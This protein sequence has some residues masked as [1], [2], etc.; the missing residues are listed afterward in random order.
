MKLFFREHIP[1]FLL[2]LMQLIITILIFWLDGYKNAS[3]ILYASFINFF[4]LTTY[5]VYQFLSHRSLYMRLTK[6]VTTLDHFQVSAQSA[7][8]TQ[9]FEHLLGILR[10]RYKKE[11]YTYKDKLDQHVQFIHQWVHQMKTPLSVID[12]ILQEQNQSQVSPIL[13]EL[14]RLNKGL[15]L[16]LYT[17]RL[18]TFDRDFYV[19]TLSLLHVVRSVTSDLKRL[20]IRKQL[21]PEIVIDPNLTITSDEKWLSFLLTQITTNA[22]RYT[23]KKGSKIIFQGKKD[24]NQIILE[25]IDSGIGIVKSDLPRVFDPHFTGE[26]GR[27]F[28]ESTGMGLYLV[29]QICQKL[30]HQIEIESMVNQ[31]T[32]V[33][34]LLK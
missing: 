18:D 12:L 20:F 14:D 1:L 27:I 8:L 6:P 16:V 19:E 25:V 21:Y 34:I 28:Q 30:G 26:N 29:K 24:G 10:Q 33:R 11:I 31:G 4:L 22:I 3:T 9:S 2:N 17:A 32:T 7:P 23:Q 5:L 13:Y 15:E